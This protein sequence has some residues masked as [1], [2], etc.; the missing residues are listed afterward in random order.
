[1]P[2][3]AQVLAVCLMLAL[4]GMAAAQASQI[5][6]G[7]IRADTSQPV[8]VTAD[9]LTVNQTDGTA[10]FSGNVAVIQGQMR[11]GADEIV[12]EYGPGD[13]T[14]IARLIA[15]GNVIL[16][17]GADAAKAGNAEYSVDSGEIVLTGSVLLT[18]G[19]NV[20]SGE[21]LALNLAAGTGQMEGRVKTVLQ[22]GGN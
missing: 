15:K 10:V 22:P 8:E 17:A 16:T 3:R 4:P 6:F 12:V 18:Q 14:R 13:R 20:L 7:G 21:R 1:M 11:L 19:A 2:L 5:A 9:Q